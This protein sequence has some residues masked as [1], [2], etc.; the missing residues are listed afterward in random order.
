MLIDLTPYKSSRHCQDLADSL[1]GAREHYKQRIEI[2]SAT[3]VGASGSMFRVFG[4][5]DKPSLIYQNWAHEQTQSK[6]FRRDVLA[7]KTQ[8]QFETL[9]SSL[10]DSLSYYWKNNARY[11][12]D[13]AK[14][15]IT[16]TL[17]Q[18]F[19]LLDLFIKRACELNL[20]DDLMNKNLLS[21]GHVPLDK[22]IF[23]A[24]DNVFSGVFLLAGRS[25]GQMKNEQSYQFYQNLIR[26]LMR[27]LQPPTEY[28]ALYFEFYAWNLGREA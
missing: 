12:K 20:R 9:H 7:L 22:W 15:E 17:A 23:T 14:K 10:A 19:K 11:L 2:D 27:E 21:F 25:M 3:S 5:I 26:Q 16:L 18:K 28:P 8:E 24:L 4:G 1:T 6:E 13:E